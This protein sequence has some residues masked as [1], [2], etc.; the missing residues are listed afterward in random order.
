MNDTGR[1]RRTERELVGPARAGLPLM[2]R[3]KFLG[4]LG[5]AASLGL[6]G[7]A[8]A[9]GANAQGSVRG[10]SRSAGQ[11]NDPRPPTVDTSDPTEV[12]DGVWI[13]RDDRVWLVPNIG[14]ILGR[15]AALVVDCGFGPANGERVLEAAR[16][17]AGSRR[18]FLTM[19]HFHPEHGFGAQAFRRDATI[20]YNR[21]QRDELAEKGERYIDLFREMEGEAAVA[22]LEGTEIVMPDSVY[23]GGRTEIDLGGRTVELRTWG[24]AHTRGDQAVFVPDG[25]ILFAGDL[26]EERMFPIFPWFPPQDVHIDDARWTSILTNDFPGFDPALVVPGHGDPG[27]IEISLALAEQI[28]TVGRRVRELSAQGRSTEQIIREYKPDVIAANPS[29]EYPELIDWEINYFAD[30]PNPGDSPA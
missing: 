9:C 24:T 8:A 11:D 3:Q 10:E 12:A 22:A 7:L 19:T 26:I 27:G 18:L 30:N 6:T 5:L 29:W 2:S 25:R 20:V 17:L 15:D 1:G 28:E 14:V 13:L 21:A 23:D 16:E 4:R